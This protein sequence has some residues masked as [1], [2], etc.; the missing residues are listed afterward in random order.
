MCLVMGA[1]F[2]E[3]DDTMLFAAQCRCGPTKTKLGRTFSTR[4]P[5][6]DDLWKTLGRLVYRCTSCKLVYCAECQTE[7]TCKGHCG[8]V[9]VCPGCPWPGPG[10]ANVPSSVW[11]TTCTECVKEYMC[12]DCTEYAWDVDPDAI[13][14]KLQTCCG[15]DRCGS[16]HFEHM[17]EAHRMFSRI[18]D[19]AVTPIEEPRRLPARTA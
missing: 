14:R 5:T 17:Q 11:A 9:S 16:C 13:P 4:T 2:T 6:E 12:D 18:V 7:R 8:L 10:V 19:L 3:G 1:T 15:G